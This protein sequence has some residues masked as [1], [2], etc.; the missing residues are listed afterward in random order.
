V[1]AVN[2]KVRK[3]NISKPDEVFRKDRERI[4]YRI[5]AV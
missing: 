4:T 1:Q 5:V 2:L 3:F